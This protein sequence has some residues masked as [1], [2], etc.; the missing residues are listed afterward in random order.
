MPPP[1]G[2][3][4]LQGASVHPVYCAVNKV[5]T[6]VRPVPGFLFITE[7]YDGV[8]AAPGLAPRFAIKGETMSG[9]T[10][11][12]LDD[13]PWQEVRPQMQGGK[14]VAVHIRQIQRTPDR[15]VLY[16]RY[17]P[18]LVLERHSHTGD[19]VIHILEGDLLV[20]D[21]P[22]LPGSTIILE[23]G[24]PFGPL[25]AGKQGT[26]ILEVFI[27]PNGTGVTPTDSEGFKRLLDAKGIT[28]LPEP[29][30]SAPL[31]SQS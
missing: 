22:C 29:S 3:N 16:T 27:G 30:R 15:V 25:I 13:I 21:V 23:K 6:V 4:P 14:R 9:L 2:G 20:G 1:D 12:N 18:G 28:L 17:D 31:G 19:E 10:I 8:G 24:T 26:T 11:E 5:D 7:V